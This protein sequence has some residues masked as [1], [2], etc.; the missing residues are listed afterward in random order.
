MRIPITLSLLAILFSFASVDATQTLFVSPQGNDNWSG[1]LATPLEDH[2]DGPLA[3]LKAARDIARSWIADSTR[4][5]EDILINLRE[6]N[7]LLSQTLELTAEDA[8]IAPAR[9]VWQ[10]YPGETVRLHGGMV[11]K[12]FKRLDRTDIVNRI[13]PQ[14]QDQVYVINLRKAG[15][16]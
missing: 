15:I 4:P 12:G 14:H 5:R 8:G 11:L 7:Y 6:G 1:R 13:P 3:S 16:D 10:A 2:S 9:V